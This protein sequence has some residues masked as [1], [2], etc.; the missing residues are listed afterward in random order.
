ML[1]TNSA[2]I[3]MERDVPTSQAKSWEERSLQTRIAFRSAKAPTGGGLWHPTPSTIEEEVKTSM[4]RSVSSG[5]LVT[6]V[7]A[8]LATGCRRSSESNGKKLEA[9]G[10]TAAGRLAL[11]ALTASKQFGGVAVGVAGM[12]TTSVQAFRTVLREVRAGAAFRY[13]LQEGR[14]AGRVY[15]L[16][17]LYLVDRASYHR[18]LP[19]LKESDDLV[20]VSRGGSDPTPA[21]C[22]I[23]ELV[24][25]TNRG[26]DSACIHLG[27]VV[28]GGLCS[29]LAGR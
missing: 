6:L 1:V 17:G 22:T 3:A 11:V 26:A 5:A 15:G 20:E 21:R 25:Q 19:R 27:D 10:L 23:A 16:C 24:D 12:P 4:L 9:L 13:A 18:E 14:A 8:V 7:L 2:G 28:S 29:S